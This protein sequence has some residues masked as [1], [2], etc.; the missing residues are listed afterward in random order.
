MIVREW[1]WRYPRALSEPVA[2]REF[3]VVGSYDRVESC[4]CVVASAMIPWSTT[5]ASSPCTSR[6]TSSNKGSNTPAVRE[7]SLHFVVP[8]TS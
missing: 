5:R 7:P 4:S 2:A 3:A 6:W 8:Y 1:K